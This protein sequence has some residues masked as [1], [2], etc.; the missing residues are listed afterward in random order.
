MLK[1]VA[2]ILGGIVVSCLALL[3][4][5]AAFQSP[6]YVISREITIQAP[7]AK[8]FPYL[9]SQRLAQAWGPWMDVDPT[10][11][12]VLSGPEEGVGARTSWSGAKQLG[13]GSAL[14]TESV[15][16]QRVHIRLEYTEPME[17]I[18]ESDYIIRSSG[19]Q[20]VVIWRVTG[21]N[22]LISRAMGLLVD[23]DK[24]VGGMFELGLSKLKKVV[25]SGK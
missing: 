17:M 16:G 10:A 22:G 24:M 12:M 20:S 7:A 21:K 6:D 9:N 23:V 5:I 19:D 8:I 18:Q 14:I 15:P 1:K 2:L 25:E 4:G 3:F 11:K 13:T